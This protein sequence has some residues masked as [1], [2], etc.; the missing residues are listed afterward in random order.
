[1]HGTLQTTVMEFDSRYTTCWG[2]TATFL[3]RLVV[4]LSVLV[5]PYPG[6]AGRQ[7]PSLVAGH[8]ALTPTIG[9]LHLDQDFRTWAIRT[10]L[11]TLMLAHGASCDM[12]TLVSQE[13][14]YARSQ[15]CGGELF[16]EL[17]APPF[18]PPSRN[19]LDPCNVDHDDYSSRVAVCM[20][21]WHEQTR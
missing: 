10:L 3:S 17:V 9:S 13:Q 6:F 7:L 4:D 15:A 5:P 12:L 21:G 16:S 2:R 1:M 20:S 18:L 19:Y 14:A 8:F 11:Q